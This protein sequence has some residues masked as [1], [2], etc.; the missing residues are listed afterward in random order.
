MHEQELISIKGNKNQLRML[1]DET[2]D[3]PVILSALHA[4]LDQ[5]G[6]FFAGAQLTIEV[7]E[8]DLSEAQ[9][10]AALE[11]MQQHGLRPDTLAANTRES[12]SIARALGLTSRP[13]PQPPPT[14]ATTPADSESTLVCRTLHSGQVL[15]HHRHVTLIGDVNAG[16]QIIAGGCVV[17]W[18]KLRGLVHAGALGDETAMVCAL[19]LRPTQL[20]I[21]HLIARTPDDMSNNLPEI[22]RIEQE[23]IVVES[24]EVYKQRL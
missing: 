16:A 23:H 13:M 1:V 15:R 3:W 10:V 7:G 12:R 18:G 22:A 19:D 9:L 5:A 20:R 14:P 11:L 21:A 17:V 24:W 4:Q 2:A 8:R 6:R